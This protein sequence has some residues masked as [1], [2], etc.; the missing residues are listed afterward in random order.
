MQS[1]KGRMKSGI[2]IILL[3]SLVLI[4]IFLVAIPVFNENARLNILEDN[5]FFKLLHDDAL[6]Y[7]IFTVLTYIVFIVVGYMAFFDWHRK[8][9][10]K[11]LLWITGFL[12]LLVSILFIPISVLVLSKYL[13]EPDLILPGVAILFCTRYLIDIL[14]LKFFSNDIVKFIVSLIF[15]FIAM[16]LYRY[17][18]CFLIWKPKIFGHGEEQTNIGVVV[19]VISFVFGVIAFLSLLFSRKGANK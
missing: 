9:E 1:Q 16:Y 12:C 6:P 10:N 8:P 3:L 7:L 19:Y 13:V 11:H 15:A 5:Y 2:V 18:V 17:T 4:F 14:I